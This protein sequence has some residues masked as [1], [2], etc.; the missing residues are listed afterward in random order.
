MYCHIQDQAVK[1]LV[2]LHLGVFVSM[3]QKACETLKFLNTQNITFT[4]TRLQATVND[5]NGYQEKLNLFSNFRQGVFEI[6]RKWF[7]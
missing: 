1:C 2:D 3:C 6:K 5:V 4:K 7:V